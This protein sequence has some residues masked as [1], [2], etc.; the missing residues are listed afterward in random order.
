M[1]KSHYEEVVDYVPMVVCG[2][3]VEKERVKRIQVY[4]EPFDHE[5]EFNSNSEYS[6]F[7]NK[8]VYR[9]YNGKSLERSKCL[10]TVAILHKKNGTKKT[11]KK[12]VLG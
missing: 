1:V 8:T 9:K 5:K 11:I 4:E 6:G 7:G 3:V 12:I 10:K 2:K